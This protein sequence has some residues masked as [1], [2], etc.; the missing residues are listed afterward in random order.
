MTI[1]E[2]FNQTPEKLLNFLI[3][4][5]TI[6]LPNQIETVEELNE[7]AEA[8]L[9][10]SQYYVYLNEL[11]AYAKILTRSVKRQKDAHKTEN[12]KTRYEDCVDKKEIIDRI[13]DS[14]K[15]QYTA[16]SRAVTIRIEANAELKL[17]S[18]G[19]IK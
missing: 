18:N 4:N 15:Q 7:A 8:M 10:L 5:F 17:N 2:V 13:A 12:Y 16:I 19:Y 6:T 3:E 14:I 9:K 1:T 11:S